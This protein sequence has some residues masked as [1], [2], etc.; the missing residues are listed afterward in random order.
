[1]R[2]WRGVNCLGAQG[3]VLS[4]LMDR[5]GPLTELDFTRSDAVSRWVAHNLDHAK[6]GTDSLGR[7][8]MVAGLSTLCHDKRGEY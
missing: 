5:C 8:T 4:E 6:G 1:M 3:L 7:A 2:A